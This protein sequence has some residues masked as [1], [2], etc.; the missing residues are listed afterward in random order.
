MLLDLLK[1]VPAYITPVFKATP[2]IRMASTKFGAWP[3]VKH[4]EGALLSKA[5]SGVVFGVH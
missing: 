1:L 2:F 4:F 3:H 5:A